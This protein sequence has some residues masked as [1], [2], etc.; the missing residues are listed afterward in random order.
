[1][2][3]ASNDNGRTYVQAMMIL[4]Y[5]E[6][7]EY[8]EVFASSLDRLKAMAERVFDANTDVL[9]LVLWLEETKEALVFNGPRIN[10]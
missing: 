6:R 5:E 10:R 8:R 2:N 3:Q 7:E 1:V 4:I 9:T